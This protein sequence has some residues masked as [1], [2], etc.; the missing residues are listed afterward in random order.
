MRTYLAGPGRFFL[1][2]L[3]IFE[4]SA[5]GGPP[6]VQEP[7]L[8]KRVG[9]GILTDYS[10]RINK[11][12]QL[13]A[14]QL[15][16]IL[17]FIILFIFCAHTNERLGCLETDKHNLQMNSSVL[18]QINS[19]FLSICD[20]IIFQ[21]MSASERLPRKFSVKQKCSIELV[22][23]KLF[24][25]GY[26]R[27]LHKFNHT[28]TL[29]ISDHNTIFY[30]PFLLLDK[31]KVF[32]SLSLI[33]RITGKRQL[34]FLTLIYLI[35]FGHDPKL[36]RRVQK[37]AFSLAKFL[38]YTSDFR[39]ALHSIVYSLPFFFHRCGFFLF[40]IVGNAF[41][42]ICRRHS[43]ENEKLKLRFGYSTLFINQPPKS[44]LHQ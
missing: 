42:E 10:I 28:N 1:L 37:C 36:P 19:L 9:T 40:Y 18:N 31:K 30:F 20:N 33:F 3:F 38:D 4:S 12:L 11:S 2:F 16:I 32:F 6:F 24:F 44:I 23:Y 21:Q 5:K 27:T 34:L 41:V 15:C 13:P 14:M 25:I 7:S 22:S 8:G 43:R 17:S 35:P 29:C 39:L 26:F